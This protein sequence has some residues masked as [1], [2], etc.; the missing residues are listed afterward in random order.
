MSKYSDFKFAAQET[1]PPPRRLTVFDTTLRDGHQSYQVA[2]SKDNCV[3]MATALENLGVDVIEAG[4]PSVVDNGQFEIVQA[5]AGATRR[6]K[7]AALVRMN[8]RD[9]LRAADALKPAGNRARLHLFIATSGDHM[10]HKLGKTYQEVL[11]MIK[12]TVPVACKRVRDVQFS[13]EDFTKTSLPFAFECIRVAI[14]GGATTIN[15]P[16][17]RGDSRLGS[18]GEQIAAV[19]KYLDRAF[20]NRGIALSVH[21]HNDRG[22]AV[23]NM[24]EGFAAGADQIECTVNGL[25]ER[26]GNADLA[27]VVTNIRDL[28]NRYPVKMK[29]K[30]S[31]LLAVS[32]LVAEISGRPIPA[33]APIVGEAMNKH[34]SGVHQAAEGKHKG[35]YQ[36]VNPAAVGHEEDGEMCFN[37]VS[38]TTGLRHVLQDQLGFEPSRELVEDV[39]R[40]VVGRGKEGL[41]TMECDVR[42]CVEMTPSGPVFRDR[43]RPRLGI[44]TP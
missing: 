9:I 17:T 26:A 36:V 15:C 41:Y 12:E 35:L 38:G 11:L 3:R 31:Q 14:K 4:S 42:A 28:S 21:T 2:F 13:L 32:Q 20:P 19:R 30:P 10:K 23:A 27:Q 37:A 40:Y 25:G 44:C 29:V 22:L 1:T 6:A 16:D 43:S 34:T 8:E 5:V 33:N 24:L 7:I 18:Y 39:F